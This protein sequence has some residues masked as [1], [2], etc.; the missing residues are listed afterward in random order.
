MVKAIDVNTRTCHLLSQTSPL[1][2]EIIKTLITGCKPLFS[3]VGDRLPDWAVKSIKL[4]VE[5]LAS[6]ISFKFLQEH[7]PYKP[8]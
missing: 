2:K 6:C 1:G 5:K 3:V 7:F 8:Q 4:Q